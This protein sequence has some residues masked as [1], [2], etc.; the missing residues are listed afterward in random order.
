[1]KG[2]SEDGLLECIAPETYRKATKLGMVGSGHNGPECLKIEKHLRSF[3]SEKCFELG[4][5][6]TSQG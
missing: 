6:Q 3:A 4:E 2:H 5:L 1:M